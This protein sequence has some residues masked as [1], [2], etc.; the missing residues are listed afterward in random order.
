M[1]A[2]PP[3]ADIRHSVYGPQGFKKAGTSKRG[4]EKK[5]LD[6]SFLYFFGSNVGGQCVGKPRPASSLLTGQLTLRS[7][8]FCPGGRF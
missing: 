8:L 5:F 2:L 7:C 6:F 1:S 4:I 3:K